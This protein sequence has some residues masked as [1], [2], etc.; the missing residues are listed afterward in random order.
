MEETNQTPGT[1][2]HLRDTTLDG[3]SF[4]Y[5]D[6]PYFAKGKSLY[7]NHFDLED[8]AALADCLNQNPKAAWLLTYDNVPEIKKLYPRRAIFEF[9]LNYSAHS[10]RKVSEILIPSDSLKR[11]L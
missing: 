11:F 9:S 8:H 10:P 1:M 2:G 7:L 6:P 4:M 5:L 3:K